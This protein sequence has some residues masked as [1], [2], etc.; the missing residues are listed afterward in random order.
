VTYAR[1]KNIQNCSALDDGT[2]GTCG[3]IEHE[4]AIWLVPEWLP[5]PDE[6][7]T[8]PKRMIRLDQ[9]R[10]QKFD[11][12]ATGPAPFVGA[13]FAINDPLPKSLF[14]GELSSQLKARYVVLDR[15]DLRVRVGGVRQ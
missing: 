10:H 8:K 11:P 12:P 5:F 9:F 6:G 2:L 7:Y 13:N 1:I 14:Y 3:G 15:P 4:G